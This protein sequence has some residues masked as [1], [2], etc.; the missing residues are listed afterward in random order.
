[1]EVWSPKLLMTWLRTSYPLQPPFPPPV[2]PSILVLQLLWITKL[3]E[4]SLPNLLFAF[5]GWLVIYQLLIVATQG[6]NTKQVVQKYKWET[7]YIIDPLFHFAELYQLLAN[8]ELWY[9]WTFLCIAL[10]LRYSVK[11]P[12]IFIVF[13]LCICFQNCF[14]ICLLYWE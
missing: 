14:L 11:Q 2:E 5:L 4:L 8:I 9:I 1:M 6:N 7:Y 3:G 12:P 10:D 13:F